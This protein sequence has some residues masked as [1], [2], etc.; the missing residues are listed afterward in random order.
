LD[1]QS[2]DILALVSSPTINP[3][4]S[5]QG[6]PPGE[7]ERRSDLKLRPEINRATQENYAPGSIFK[8]VVGLACLEAG[9]DPNETI[10]NPGYYQF[11]SGGRPVKDLAAPGQYN[12]E[13]ALVKSS[14]TYFIQN[15]L[16]AGIENLFKKM[17]PE[18]VE[19]VEALGALN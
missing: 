12:F 3:N 17:M 9:L 15:G 5:V 19:E 10:N 1:V 14:N 7:K 18:E 6:L 8:P 11:R 13:R 2:G 4:D 16:K